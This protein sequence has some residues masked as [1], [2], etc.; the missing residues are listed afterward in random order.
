MYFEEPFRFVA[1]HVQPVRVK[2]RNPTLVKLWW[3]HEKSRQE[4]RDALSVYP[5]FIATP[6]VAKHRVFCWI[7]NGTLPDCALVASARD[8]DPDE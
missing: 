2:N 4:M 7:P 3:I 1:L 8:D 6:R 5:R